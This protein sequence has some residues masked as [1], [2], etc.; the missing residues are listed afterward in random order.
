MET[1]LHSDMF[2]K[3]LSNLDEI[4]LAKKPIKERT[5]KEKVW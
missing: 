1:L 5:L 3:M 4:I 2:T